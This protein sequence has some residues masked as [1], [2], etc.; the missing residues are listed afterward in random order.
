MKAGPLRIT[1]RCEKIRTKKLPQ[2][3]PRMF[4]LVRSFLRDIQE[5]GTTIYKFRYTWHNFVWLAESSIESSRK[6]AD[7]ICNEN[8]LLAQKG[9]A[10]KFSVVTKINALRTGSGFKTKTQLTKTQL[11]STSE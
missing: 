8:R 9:I 6:I 10:P 1:F 5:L 7:K 3:W 4:S 11:W 2:S